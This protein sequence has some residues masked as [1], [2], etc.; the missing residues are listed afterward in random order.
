LPSLPNA[1]RL[2][3][4]LW[5]VSVQPFKKFGSRSVTLTRMVSSNDT[6]MVIN[7]RK[8]QMKIAHRFALSM[9][10]VLIYSMI[11]IGLFF[12]VHRAWN[13]VCGNLS[14]SPMADNPP[15]GLC[16]LSGLALLAYLPLAGAG[17][18]YLVA[19]IYRRLRGADKASELP[20][21]FISPVPRAR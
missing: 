4:P 3:I 9:G 18:V 7:E 13:G 10:C 20:N 5:T 11:A 19:W 17:V 2:M 1:A 16:A 15:L 14:L 6:K 12:I 21:E 8:S